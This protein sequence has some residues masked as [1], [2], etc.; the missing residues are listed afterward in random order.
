MSEPAKGASLDS[1]RSQSPKASPLRRL[2][3]ALAVGLGAG[4]VPGAPGTVGSAEGAL[5]AWV[6]YRLGSWPALVAVTAALTAVAFWS[7]AVAEAHYGEHDSQHIVIDEVAGQLL[8]LLPVSCTWPHVLLGFG[9]FRLFDSLKPWPA[10][11]V[12]RNVHGGAGVVLD[13]LVAGAQAAAATALLVHT[14]WLDGA[15]GW[16]G[17]IVLGH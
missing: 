7:A 10:G 3:L 8:T 4:H 15:L 13:D 16:L 1:V 5:L 2:G 6:A 12:D 14:G 17:R 9:F 11:W